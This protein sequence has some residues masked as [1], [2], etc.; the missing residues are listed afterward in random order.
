MYPSAESM[1]IIVHD[2]P[3]NRLFQFDATSI[4]GFTVGDLIHVLK[5]HGLR[6]RCL[7]GDSGRLS[8]DLPLTI[9]V[10]DNAS[11][12]DVY[13]RSCVL[14]GTVTV[15]NDASSGDGESD[16]DDA[17][18]PDVHLH[19]PQ[20]LRRDSSGR[21]L[22]QLADR[23]QCPPIFETD[24]YESQ[25]AKPPKAFRDVTSTA[26]A[27]TNAAAQP[28]ATAIAAIVA[29]SLAVIDAT[30]H[31]AAPMQA[32]SGS[33]S[34]ASG[35]QQQP[36]PAVSAALA[37]LATLRDRARSNDDSHVDDLGLGFGSSFALRTWTAA[38]A[39]CASRW[40]IAPAT[41]DVA[42]DDDDADLPDPLD[43]GGAGDRREGTQSRRGRGRGNTAGRASVS[44]PARRIANVAS[45]PTL[46][47]C[48]VAGPAA[49]NAGIM[50]AVLSGVWNACRVQGDGVH[51]ANEVHLDGARARVQLSC[52]G[53]GGATWRFSLHECDDN[54]RSGDTA[55]GA[56]GPASAVVPAHTAKAATSLTQATTPAT[57]RETEV[58]PASTSLVL[59]VDLLTLVPG[60]DTSA[61]V[62]SAANSG[63]VA[64]RIPGRGGRGAR[65]RGRGGRSAAALAAGG[66]A[67]TDAISAGGTS[68]ASRQATFSSSAAL[69]VAACVREMMT[70]GGGAGGGGVVVVVGRQAII[71]AVLG[72]D[73]GSVRRVVVASGSTTAV[74]QPDGTPAVLEEAEAPSSEPAEPADD[75]HAVVAGTSAATSGPGVIVATRRRR[76]ACDTRAAAA[77]AALTILRS[78]APDGASII[79]LPPD[80]ACGGYYEL[81]GDAARSEPEGAARLC[82]CRAA[83]SEAVCLAV[84]GVRHDVSA[85]L[86]SL[87]AQWAHASR[88]CSA[89]RDDHRSPASA[90][91]PAVRHHSVTPTPEAPSCAAARRVEPLPRPTYAQP[92]AAA[93]GA[94]G[95]SMAVDG[96][97]AMALLASAAAHHTAG[98]ARE[99]S[100]V[101]DAILSCPP[102]LVRTFLQLVDHGVR[103]GVG[104]VV[105]D[106]RDV[107]RVV[108]AVTIMSHVAS[109]HGGS[110]R[111][112]P[113][114]LSRAVGPLRAILGVCGCPLC[115]AVKA[116]DSAYTHGG[117]RSNS[118]V[119]LGTAPAVR[120]PQVQWPQP[121]TAAFAAAAVA[122]SPALSRRARAPTPPPAVAGDTSLVAALGCQ[123]GA[124]I[125][126]VSCALAMIASST[127]AIPAVSTSLLARNA[128]GPSGGGG[129]RALVVAAA[130]VVHCAVASLHEIASAARARSMGA[131]VPASTVLSHIY[132]PAVRG[133]RSGGL[134][135]VVT[136]RVSTMLDTASADAPGTATPPLPSPVSTMGM[137]AGAPTMGL[138]GLGLD[139][140]RAQRSFRLGANT[141]APAPLAGHALV[142]DTADCDLAGTVPGAMCP[143]RSTLTASTVP[144]EA[145]A[146]V[147]QEVFHPLVTAI[148][149]KRPRQHATLGRDGD[150]SATSATRRHPPPHGGRPGEAQL[151][152]PP[153]WPA[154]CSAFGLNHRQTG[155]GS[156]LHTPTL[157]QAVDAMTRSSVVASVVP[158]EPRARV[159]LSLLTAPL[160]Q[161][162]PLHTAFL[163]GGGP[164]AVLLAAVAVAVDGHAGGAMACGDAFESFAG[165]LGASASS[166]THTIFRAGFKS[167]VLSAPSSFPPRT[168]LP[169]KPAHVA[170]AQR[171]FTFD[172]G[173]LGAASSVASTVLPILLAQRGTTV[174]NARAVVAATCE[175]FGVIGDVAGE[176]IAAAREEADGPLAARGEE[177]LDEDG[178]QFGEHRS[179]ASAQR[180]PTCLDVLSYDA[181]GAV[182]AD[183]DLLRDVL[184]LFATAMDDLSQCGVVIVTPRPPP[185]LWHVLRSG[186]H[187]LHQRTDVVALLAPF[188]LFLKAG[189]EM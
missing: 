187:T 76:V 45:A 21:P 69:Y 6:R 23:P 114:E 79:D 37:R 17:I 3:A 176:M 49:P 98:A 99:A 166:R 181:T 42:D 89:L 63:A 81:R 95:L 178:R 154:V 180:A 134:G 128:A 92:L 164:H 160:R 12:S 70:S 139:P 116:A 122:S 18:H 10:A 31:T 83:Y 88:V 94:A 40:G 68:A 186:G 104:G 97:R 30:A 126:D 143:L 48:Q 132:N 156:P 124:T 106:D 47:L 130:R 137:G 22:V 28:A 75:E 60:Q 118:A 82:G 147:H 85:P 66:A 183:A 149:W 129:I 51:A 188:S 115:L 2:V 15:R 87:S 55:E 172:A 24:A 121:V 16:S 161:I 112:S 185:D 59:V 167:P 26:I 62:I 19:L 123:F 80:G 148:A 145:T 20:H 72:G 163:S 36:P 46:V 152:L 25:L 146:A 105:A 9:V 173:V 113:D 13:L 155:R 100:L 54:D 131:V 107:A 189:L 144:P 27:A 142:D 34:R 7:Y 52:V 71:E 141:A 102:A 110:A 14:R 58:D 91:A 127:D 111:I 179:V 151:A 61:A 171:A 159:G 125:D 108:R 41:A 50:S 35:V 157:E 73:V 174:S 169:T 67:T 96:W 32:E 182:Y 90:V 162:P 103:G 168:T 38:T 120:R 135:L 177:I 43:G 4:S 119:D 8:E 101:S 150:G 109:G 117:E 93:D 140:L 77:G 86:R 1:P 64:S 170:G 184:A 33:R 138:G 84:A 29:A 165:R 133:G 158:P 5:N 65:G 56:G 53:R 78:C 44:A 11:Y 175:D 39:R 136:P 153:P 57:R 74:Q